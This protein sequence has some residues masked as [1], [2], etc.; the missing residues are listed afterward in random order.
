VIL[1]SSNIQT[2]RSASCCYAPRLFDSRKKKKWNY[3]F[4]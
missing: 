4:K 2:F 1:I 3:S